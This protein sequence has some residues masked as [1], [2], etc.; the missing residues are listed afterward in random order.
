LGT[1][2][3]GLVCVKNGTIRYYDQQ[4]YQ[5]PRAGVRDVLCDPE[6]RVWFNCSAHKL[7]GL[8]LLS[9]DKIE[10]FTPSN[11]ALPDN[12]VKSIAFRNRKVYVATG[13]TVT[14]QKVA[15]LD[16]DGWKTLPVTGY[17]LMDM[18]VDLEGKVYVIDDTGLSSSMITNKIYVLDQDGFRDILQQTNRFESTPYIVKTDLRN[19]LWVVQFTQDMNR[20]L[21][22]YDGKSWHRAPED[23]PKMY[24]KCLSVDR[25]NNLWLGT[26]QGIFVLDQ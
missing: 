15:V 26:E 25:N 2:S 20:T 8:G 3:S 1:F 16:E 7:G 19:Y 23:F 6:G 5:L 14:Q 12:L 10:I 17:Y 24:I 4:N 21:F 18:D 22:L 13:G 9:G 11:S